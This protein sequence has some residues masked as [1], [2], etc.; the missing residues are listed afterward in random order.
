MF[1]DGFPEDAE[2]WSDNERLESVVLSPQRITG[3][4]PYRLTTTPGERII[5]VFSPSSPRCGVR[6]DPTILAVK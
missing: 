6:S 1:G 5:T 2:V 3:V 4:I